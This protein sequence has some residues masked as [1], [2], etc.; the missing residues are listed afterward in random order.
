MSGRIILRHL[1][2]VGEGR[3]VA[4]LRFEDGV[5]VV[6]GASNT[7]KSF[8]LAALKYMLGS[9]TPPSANEHM[10]GYEAA[11]LGLD[12]PGSGAKTLYRAIKGGAFRLYDGLHSEVPDDATSQVLV[13]EHV[14]NRTDTLSYLIL[15][16]LDID[17]RKIV[18]NENGEQNNF[19]LRNFDPF[20]FVDESAIIEQR[21]PIL[22]GQR[23]SATYEKNAFRLM[24]TG[25][26]D[27]AV[28][29]VIPSK[30]RKARQAGQKEL[31]EQWIAD[32]DKQIDAV[33]KD[34]EQ[35]ADQSK[36]LEASLQTLQS[37]LALRQ[38][39]ID[40]ATSERRLA[41]DQRD[42]T[43]AQAR[44]VELTLARFARLMEIY[45]SD[46][47]R[48]NA[49]EQ[50]GHL[51]LARLDRPCPLCG[52]EAEHHHHDGKRDVERAKATARAEVARIDRERQDLTSTINL[53]EQDGIRH[54]DDLQRVARRIAAAD[55]LLAAL[56]PEEAHLRSGYQERLEKRDEVREN[57]KLYED[58]D[59]LAVQLSQISSAP[60][61][62]KLNLTV[63]IDGPTGH[64]FS[65][66]VAEVLK[67]WGFPGDPTVSFDSQSQDI[68]LNGKERRA[69]GKGV[70]AVL[71]SAFKVATLLFCQDRGLPH[72]GILILDTPLLTYREPIKVPRY[73]ELAADEKA[74][75][76]TP[77]H[78]GFYR[79]LA[80]LADQAQFIILENSDPPT[81]LVP[82][83]TTH[84]FTGDPNDG[85]MG[86]FPPPPPPP[87]QAVP[88]EEQP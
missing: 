65:V 48:L 41:I 22:S 76:A 16:Y 64:E 59:R 33:G 34:R 28:V 82:S 30:I 45:E 12:L 83:I 52:A 8:T 78:E 60:A 2:F 31:I 32:I 62:A 39:R 47:E 21:S 88:G 10:D 58:R 73:G 42:K 9:S 23:D 49:L 19:T 7:G 68:W 54:A 11:L 37:D 17:G 56:R 74:L 35:L 38:Q 5:N 27:T 44:E 57:L 80:S 15:A 20:I 53:L 84:L 1:A 72:P 26:D 50:G 55:R 6:Y 61:P 70:R 24:L 14:A 77:L 3:P 66:K 86:F 79:H 46:V 18:R 25:R 4:M 67:A 40:A 36:Q 85:R 75:A 63:G 13:A 71:H 81:A 43:S 87:G 29:P 69:N 51:L